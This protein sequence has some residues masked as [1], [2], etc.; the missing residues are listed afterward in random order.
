MWSMGRTKL[1]GYFNISDLL[2]SEDMKANKSDKENWPYNEEIQG[3]WA[4]MKIT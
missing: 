4:Q 3:V 2:W 1:E